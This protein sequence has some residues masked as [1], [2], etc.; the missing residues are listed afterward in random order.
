MVSFFLNGA[1]LR[2][3]QIIKK[4]KILKK[5]WWFL[6]I[7]IIKI[8]YSIFCDLFLSTF[9][10]NKHS[11][12]YEWITTL[13]LADILVSPF[14]NRFQKIYS[15][16][17]LSPSIEVRESSN[18]KSCP[19]PICQFVSVAVLHCV[20]LAW[21]GEVKRAISRFADITA[22]Y[23]K[24]AWIGLS[25][26]YGTIKPRQVEF[27]YVG[28]AESH[29]G[30]GTATDF[31]RKTGRSTSLTDKEIRF[32]QIYIRLTYYFFPIS[33]L[34]WQKSTPE[35]LEPAEGTSTP[36][37]NIGQAEIESS[38]YKYDGTFSDHLEMLVQMG[39]V[40][41][42]SAAFPLAG[43]CAL[44]NNLLEIRSDAFKLAHVHQVGLST[45]ILYKY[46]CFIS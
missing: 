4:L 33:W 8:R 22:N 41:L 18:C 17:K 1:Y 39:Y 35:K 28:R 40:V 45:N 37:R 3:S 19:I 11:S 5:Y 36:K 13:L 21:S 6:T 20:L 27:Q 16:R 26:F 15:C 44:A 23:W 24:L 14:A 12:F 32:Y 43:F 30:N 29:T 42:F 7:L 38:F 9:S 10:P 46:L 34:C 31:R 25:I 2:N